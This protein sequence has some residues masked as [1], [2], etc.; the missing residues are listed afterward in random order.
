MKAFT[1][2]AAATA[3]FSSVYAASVK[4]EETPCIQNNTQLKSFDVTIGEL[5]VGTLESV[6]GLKIVSAD[7]VDITK[8]ECQAFKDAE[9]KVPGSA[10]FT[11]SKPALIATNPVQ[12]GS[13]KCDV[14][15]GSSPNSTDTTITTLI[16]ATPTGTGSPA[17]TGG[18]NTISTTGTPTQPSGPGA[19][20]SGAPNPTAAGNSAG[21]FGLSIGALAIGAVAFVL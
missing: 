18:N 13:V 19:T 20:N 12:E 5:K 8:V 15:G 14:V 9:G 3:L 2:L 4:L 6:C 10:K 16:T 21:R 1:T 17:P 11:S 7:G